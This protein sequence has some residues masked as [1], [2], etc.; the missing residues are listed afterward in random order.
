MEWNTQHYK[1]AID[2]LF[3]RIVRGL[4]AQEWQQSRIAEGSPGCAYRG[5]DGRRCAVGV[6]IPDEIYSVDIEGDIDEALYAIHKRG[7]LHAFISH[8]FPGWSN[9][10]IQSR[11]DWLLHLE[12]PEY[13]D[14]L[15]E[16]TL[17]PIAKFLSEAQHIHDQS[18]GAPMDERFARFSQEHAL[19][20]P[21]DVAWPQFE[22]SRT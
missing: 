16:A 14:D 22:T 3:Q 6:L 13:L 12:D 1:A 20:W 15:P 18:A 10:E 21:A 9:E 5:F 2:S 4:A 8:L 17:G 7:D 11:T 19:T